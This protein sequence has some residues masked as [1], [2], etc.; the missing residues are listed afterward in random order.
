VAE[1]GF[2]NRSKNLLDGATTLS[3]EERTY[4]KDEFGPAR[5]RMETMGATIGTAGS[6]LL[7]LVALLIGFAQGT[8]E[9]GDELVTAADE[10]RTT[11]LQCDPQQPSEACTREKIQQAVAKVQREE[12]QLGDL[13]RQSKT[14]AVVAGLALAGFLLGFCALLTNPIPG[15]EALKGTGD[16]GIQDWRNTRGRLKR[17]RNWIILSLIVQVVAIVFLVVL[18]VDVFT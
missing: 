17:K 15:F 9:Q 11:A 8:N 16:E 10:A 18:G 13:G 6:F 4:L 14:Q 3:K 2:M 7:V 5:S 12:E 1:Y